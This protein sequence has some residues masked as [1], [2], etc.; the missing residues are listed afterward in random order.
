MSEELELAQTAVAQDLF[1]PAGLSGPEAPRIPKKYALQRCLGRGGGGA[2]YLAHDSSLGRPVALKLLSRSQPAEVERFF[3]EAR[4]AARLN[5]PSIVQI[6]EA[7]EHRGQPF[8]AMQY[9][10]GGNLAGAELDIR[11]ILQAL[12]QVGTALIHAHGEGI[13]HRDIKPENILLDHD[14]HAYL[15]DFGIARDLRGELGSTISKD[16]QI[17]GT[18]ALM[19][20]EQARGDVQA[21]DAR[22]DIYALGATL[23]LKLTG[24]APFQA[25]NLVDLLYAVIH[26][27]PPFPRKYNAAI[28]RDLEAIILRCMR[29]SREQRYGSMQEVL[30]AFDQV[31]GG[32]GG[33][34]VSPAW[35]TSYVRGRV[36]EAPAPVSSQE[37]P[38]D[39]SEWAAAMKVAREIAAWDL[40]LY[41]VTSDLTRYFPRLDELIAR[42]DRVLRERPATGWARFYRG[43]AWFRRGELR[44]ALEDME[45]SIDRVRDLAGAYFELG[46]LYLAIYLD[47]HQAAHRH[48]SRTGV[49]EHL[50]SARTR[51]EQAGVAFAEARRLRQLPLW[52]VRYAEAVDRLAERDYAGCIALCDSILE[53]EPDLEELHKLKGDAQRWSGADPLPAYRR[54]LEI[55]RSYYEA[56]LAIAEVHAEAGA[57]GEARSAL[58]RALELRSDLGSAQVMLARLALIE[59]RAGGPL[60]EL[61]AGVELARQARAAHPQRYDAAVTLAELQIELGRRSGETPWID[62][63]L[64]NLE[65]ADQLEGCHNRVGFLRAQARLERGRQRIEAGGDA[66]GDLEAVQAL[67]NTVPTQVPDNA[68]W[69]ELFAAAEREF[70]RLKG[71]E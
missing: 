57:L 15:T 54:A 38:E 45:R 8:I 10:P 43:I 31:L 51:L 20:P 56:L 27:P 26:D 70:A 59:A 7:G 39:Q 46:R 2:V 22:S 55:R 66:R 65:Q 14:R 49:E 40:Q 63:A 47:E 19:A 34:S 42:L 36:E 13:V 41:R 60:S 5:S 25:E 61:Q 58:Q 30:E 12:R 11:G 52:Q 24:H 68:S 4:F 32:A 67:R 69:I 23:F 44:R 62:Q 9:I 71:K 28:P 29:K 6:Y 16:G 21:V 50:R 35:F 18:P 33:G 53:D 17:M 3:R 37:P 48:M 64:E 1:G